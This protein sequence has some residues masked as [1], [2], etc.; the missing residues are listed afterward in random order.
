LLADD[1][2]RTNNQTEIFFGTVIY[3]HSELE[4]RQDFVWH[5]T[6]DNVVNENVR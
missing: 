3:D 2:L 4:E 5:T 6:E 1:I